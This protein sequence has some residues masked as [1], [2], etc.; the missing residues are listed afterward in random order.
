[1]WTLYLY[2]HYLKQKEMGIVLAET[3]QVNVVVLKDEEF[4]LYSAKTCSQFISVIIL[5]DRKNYIQ[6]LFLQ[7]A[8]FDP[9]PFSFN[10]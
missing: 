9:T 4:G 3:Q 5:K 7:L 10:L 8:Y 1:M 6:K 2:F